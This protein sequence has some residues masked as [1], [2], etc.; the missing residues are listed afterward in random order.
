MNETSEQSFGLSIIIT[1]Y[2]YARFLGDAIRSALN[3]QWNKVEVIVVDDGSTDE[4][5]SVIQEFSEK[6][7]YIYQRNSGQR[8]ACNTGYAK[9]T[10]DIIIFLD[11]DDMLEPSVAVEIARVW[12]SGISKV[13]FQLAR[14]DE[15][16]QK[17]G[18]ISPIYDPLPTPDLIREWSLTTSAYPSPPGSGNAYARSFLDRIF[19]IGEACGSSGDSACIAAA[20]LLGDVITIPKPLARYRLHSSNDSNVHQDE[21]SFGREVSRAMLRFSYQQKIGK[22]LGLMLPDETLFRSLHL[23]QH[24][25]ASLRL[26]PALH[27]LAGDS[28]WRATRDTLQA[29]VSFGAMSLKRRSILA[30]WLLLTLSMPLPVARRLVALKFRR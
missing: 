5:R 6:V 10:G 28:R 12:R 22:D 20:P 25:A 19:P 17:T 14:M 30:A 23:L 1:N 13:Q 18:S 29:L 26:T 4:S 15:T 2:N 3:V 24:R 21:R 27:P 16:G 8:A 9:A 11:A 7:K